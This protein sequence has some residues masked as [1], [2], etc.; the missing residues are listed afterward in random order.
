MNIITRFAPSPTGNLHVGNIRTALVNWIFARKNKGIFILRID[1]TDNA[2]NMS[3]HHEKILHDL[4]WLNIDYDIMFQQSNRTTRYEE[5]QKLLIK[6]GYLYPCFE[7]S[8]ELLKQR[9]SAK[10]LNLPF[11]Y[12]R[13][14]LSLSSQDVENKTASGEKPHYR[15]K[16]DHTN[17]A[18]NDLIRGTISYDCKNISDPVLV[19][20]DGTP[21]YMLCS[22]IDDMDYKITHIIRGEDHI[23][24]TA[25]QIQLFHAISSVLNLEN[26]PLQQLD[27]TQIV[28]EK[29]IQSIKNQESNIALK[30]ARTNKQEDVLTPSFGHL[31]LLRSQNDKISKRLGGY[32]I[33]TLR[34]DENLYYLSVINFLTFIGTSQSLQTYNTIEQ[35]FKSFDLH[36]YSKNSTKYSLEELIEFNRKL[37]MTLDYKD[38]HHLVSIK[39]NID[40]NES[41]WNIIKSNVQNIRDICVWW[42][43]LYNPEKVKYMKDSEYN[44]DSQ[45]LQKSF[46]NTFESSYEQCYNVNFESIEYAKLIKL[47]SNMMCDSLGV[48]KKFVF[49][50][51]R[52]ALT[53]TMGGPELKDIISLLS[54]SNVQQRIQNY[55]TD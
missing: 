38:V 35:I 23:T 40:I 26:I 55:F 21:T 13:N 30:V 1:D 2:R 3:E 18:W 54:K 46:L 41:F 7:T 32:S 10:Q 47:W 25:I 9:D 5:I 11:I 37:I 48:P 24:N 42:K 50:H 31:S 12:N 53:G 16:L 45:N 4:K 14:A 8:E 22:V 19:R 52:L 6:H 39:Y 49:K 43:S 17:I 36:S 34:E 44:I 33:D 15:F 28:N 51:I 27:N 29:D 20:P